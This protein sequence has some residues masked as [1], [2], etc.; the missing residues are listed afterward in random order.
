MND[1]KV[2]IWEEVI[3]VYLKGLSLSLSEIFF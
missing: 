1:D 3:V 2:R